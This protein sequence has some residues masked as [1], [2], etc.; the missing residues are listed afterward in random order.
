MDANATVTLD[1]Y[2]A[3]AE[4]TKWVKDGEY[5]DAISSDRINIL[6]NGSLQIKEFGSADSGEYW[7][8]AINPTSEASS[9]TIYVGLVRKYKINR[10]SST[11]TPS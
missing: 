1:C 6:A 10:C 7:C 8:F 11:V 3:R 9:T 4:T 5:V 2:S